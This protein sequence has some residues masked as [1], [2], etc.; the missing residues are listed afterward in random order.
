MCICRLSKLADLSF[1]RH[2]DILR[3]FGTIKVCGVLHIAYQTE[4]GVNGEYMVCCLFS[5]HLLLAAP[6]EEHRKFNVVAIIL[7][8]DMRLEP[9]DNGIGSILYLINITQKKCWTFIGLHCDRV[10]F[11]WKIIFEAHKATYELVL[12]AC[13]EKEITQWKNHILQQ[14]ATETTHH[15]EE[16]NV[17]EESS[18]VQLSLKPLSAVVLDGQLRNI[19]RRSSVDGSPNT[20]TTYADFVHLLIKGTQAIPQ[21]T[22]ANTFSLGRS[23]SVQTPRQTVVLATRRQS[24]IRLERWLHD[25]W[26]SDILPYPGMPVWRG[27]H[28]IRSSAGSLIRKLSS[29]RPFMRRSSSLAT[30]MTIKSVETVFSHKDEDYI[31]EKEP[32]VDLLPSKI[33]FGYEGMDEDKFSSLETLPNSEQGSIFK[34]RSQ[35]NGMAFKP[36][37]KKRWSVS[38]FKATFA[39]RPQHTLAIN[40]C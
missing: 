36:C 32:T 8:S 30:T 23:L 24:R 1:Q 12:S 29:R 7:L 39:P 19:T 37:I 38:L 6:S 26:T 20:T 14:L 35:Q 3:N 13:S 15:L 18:S 31:E 28:L 40:A 27:E 11:T 10:P 4:E 34:R 9:A 17:S 5:G 33:S 22:H 16:R 2:R 21:D 25:I